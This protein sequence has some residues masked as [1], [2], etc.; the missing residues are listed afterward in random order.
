MLSLSQGNVN[1]T[2]AFMQG[3][4]KHMW[5]FVVDVKNNPFNPQSHISV[6]GMETMSEEIS[7]SAKH[8]Q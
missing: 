5:L 6:L 1:A 4:L 8:I 3:E 2:T 7:V